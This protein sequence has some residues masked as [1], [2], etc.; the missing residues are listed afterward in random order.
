MILHPLRERHRLVPFP[1]TRLLSD[2]FGLVGVALPDPKQPNRIWTIQNVF[3]PLPRCLGGIRARCLDQKS[4]VSFID[5]MSLEVLLGVGEPGDDCGW[6]GTVYPSPADLNWFGFCCDPIDLAD[7]LFVQE[8]SL[9]DDHPVLPNGLELQRRV[10]LDDTQDVIDTHILLWDGDRETGR[11]PDPR[12]ETIEAR[13]ARAD[14]EKV[15]WKFL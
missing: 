3:E 11:C 1:G 9:R 14:R 6:A 2:D 15:R 10:H 12:L 13:W 8:L 7:D 5:Q 4:F